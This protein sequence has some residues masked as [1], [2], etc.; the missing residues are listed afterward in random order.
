MSSDAAGDWVRRINRVLRLVGLGIVEQRIGFW[1]SSSGQITRRTSRYGWK[2]GS[3][4]EAALNG[5]G[6]TGLDRFLHKMTERQP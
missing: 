3:A 5:P 6:T 2:L 1:S 4:G